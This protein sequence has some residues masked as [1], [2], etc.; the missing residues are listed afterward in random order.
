MLPP[1]TATTALCDALRALDPASAAAA[2]FQ[3]TVF[4]DAGDDAMTLFRLLSNRD[5]TRFDDL[6][7]S[8]PEQIRSTVVALSPLDAAPRLRAPV[9]LA[10]APHDRYFP[11]AE[12]RTL[13]AA[14]PNVRLTVT[15]LLA[16]ATP[17]LS[18]RYLAEL[19]RLNGFFVRSLAAAR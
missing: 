18:P 11:V 19:G 16:H 14:S 15:S 9:E 1:T 8:L 13:V 2:Q 5:P 4:R 3:E 6:Y 10:T 7:A 17:R 12:S